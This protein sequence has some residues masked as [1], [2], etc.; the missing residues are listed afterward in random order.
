MYADLILGKNNCLNLGKHRPGEKK[1]SR[2]TWYPYIK[3]MQGLII[4]A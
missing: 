3:A 1:K 2:K 4:I